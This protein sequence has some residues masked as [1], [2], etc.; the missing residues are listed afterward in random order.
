MSRE[1]KPADPQNN[2]VQIAGIRRIRRRIKANEKTKVIANVQTLP[3]S[4]SWEKHTSYA[5]TH[6][7]RPNPSLASS[8]AS[9]LHRST[10]T[11]TTAWPCTSL[12]A[13]VGAA[14]GPRPVRCTSGQF[15]QKEC[16]VPDH[17]TSTARVG[18]ACGC[19]ILP[20]PLF[21]LVPYIQD[22]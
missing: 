9:S 5:Q 18:P 1:W 7:L 10:C 19:D 15:S 17:A 20:L 16:H 22:G 4:Q 12:L 3:G 2:Q 6:H 11:Y 21:P 14:G 8:Q 13:C